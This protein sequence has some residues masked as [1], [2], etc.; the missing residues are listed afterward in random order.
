MNKAQS[1]VEAQRQRDI[2]LHCADQIIGAYRLG[3]FTEI[4]KI[5]VIKS[6]LFRAIEAAIRLQTLIDSMDKT[7]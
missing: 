3:E 6:Y 1:L 4:A 2:L 5:G 7:Q